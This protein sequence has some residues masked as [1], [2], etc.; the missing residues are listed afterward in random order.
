MTRATRTSPTLANVAAAAGVSRQT[1]SNVINT[2]GRVA[3]ETRSRVQ[4]AIETLNYRPNRVARSL[5]T[6]TSRLLGY[7]VQPAP[8]GMLNPVLDRF[9]HA[10][11]ESAAEHGFHVL[12]FT[13][14]AGA[15]GLDRYAELLAQQAVDGFV[16]S[17]TVVGDPR[18]GWLT[19]HGV[20]FSAFGRTWTGEDQGAWVDVDGAAGIG[21]AVAHVHAAGHRRI[22]FLG[23]PDGSGVGDDRLAGYQAG[24]RRF[25]VAP[26]VVRTDGGIEAGRT[27][28]GGLLDRPD[29]PS[30]LVCVSDLA[31]HGALRAVTE[32]GLRP[33]HDIAITGFD[34]TP[35]AALP[36]IE[37][38]SLSQP[39][40]QVG[41]AVVR[42]VL[43]PLGAAGP[44]TPPAGAAP[45]QLFEPTL[46]IRSSSH[47]K[48]DGGST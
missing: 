38:T 14:P 20:P 22:G 37:L 17:D 32:R 33:G 27:A 21:Q 16:L 47:P 12:L 15:P 48:D 46:V 24:C 42:M 11:T 4:A 25:G 45:H 19:A 9:V 5:R 13:A 23:W 41:R 29:P 1:V 44:P 31:A 28:A 43:G 40:E 26:L 7:C 6:R 2:P 3:P 30:A 18:H 39:I 35:S 36:G 10:I 8:V 34:D